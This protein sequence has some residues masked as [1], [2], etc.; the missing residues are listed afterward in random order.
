MVFHVCML[1]TAINCAAVAVVR[2]CV[3]T[4]MCARA[5]YGGLVSESE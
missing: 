5:R 2:M 3:C 4:G 1:I